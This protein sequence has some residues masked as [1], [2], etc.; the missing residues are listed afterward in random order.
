MPGY[1]VRTQAVFEA[2][3]KHLQG[4]EAA[5]S[6]VES[7]LTEHILVVLCG[8]IQRALYTIADERAQRSRELPDAIAAANKILDS[9]RT[10]LTP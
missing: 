10:A 2:C 7:Y 9:A 4:T 8:D 3:Q 1:L 6:P 5:G